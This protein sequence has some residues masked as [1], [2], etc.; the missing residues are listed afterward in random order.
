MGRQRGRRRMGRA[1]NIIALNGA[2]TV[3]KTTIANALAKLSDDVKVLS[4]AAP[5]RAML[6]AMGV[7]AYN[8]NVAKEKP[9]KGI[10]K[11]ARELLCTLGTDWGRNMVSSE[12]WIWAMEKQMQ[13]IVDNTDNPDDLVIVIDDCR[14]PNEAIMIHQMH[15]CVVRLL[16]DGIEYDSTHESEQ[17]LPDDLID[18]EFDAGGVQNCL[19]NIVQN[20]LI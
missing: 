5:L 1:G 20:I 3:G 11:S 4:F 17:P 7:D 19:K 16:R 12:I 14:F 13:R 15:G 8:M 2:K 10:E 18:Y 6:K 9:I